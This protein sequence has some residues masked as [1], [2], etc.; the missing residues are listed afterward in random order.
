MES[1]RWD[2]ITA[3]YDKMQ[4]RQLLET[5][6][7]PGTI[8]GHLL[9]IC[10]F[11]RADRRDGRWKGADWWIDYY[12]EFKGIDCAKLREAIELY[13]QKCRGWHDDAEDIV[14]ELS[15]VENRISFEQGS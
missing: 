9:C 11:A 1:I 12:A 4:S 13:W 14:E 5:K 6:A 8:P 3:V 10:A 2:D 7:R 15:K